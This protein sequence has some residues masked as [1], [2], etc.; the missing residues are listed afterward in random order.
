MYGEPVRLGT[1]TTR[2]MSRASQP[3]KQ[4]GTLSVHTIRASGQRHRNNRPDTILHPTKAKTANQPL[5]CRS[6]PHRTF[7]QTRR[8]ESLPYA[9]GI[10]FG[11]TQSLFANREHLYQSS[12]P[13]I[14]AGVVAFVGYLLRSVRISSLIVL[15]IFALLVIFAFVRRRRVGGRRSDRRRRLR[16]RCYCATL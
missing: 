5:Q 6:H 8:V 11:T 14:T 15:A 12:A 10:C 16:W 4:N 13:G 9:S 1:R 7:S 3:D 2:R